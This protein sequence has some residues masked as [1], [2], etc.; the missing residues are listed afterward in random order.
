M[1]FIA[2][3]HIHSKYSRATSTDLDLGRLHAAAQ[4]KGIQVLGTGDFTHPAWWQ[5]INEQLVPAEEGLF[6]L[7]P[8]LAQQF[9][10]T[11]PER[12]RAPVR[13]MLVTEISNVYKKDGRTRKNHNLV[14]MPDF[15]AAERFTKKLD[16]IGNVRSDGRP[17]LGLPARDLLE[18]V[19]E[20]SPRAYLIPAHI[21]T[22]WFS[23]LGSK[24]GFDAVEECF[25]DLSHHIFALETGLSSDPPMNWRV[26]ALDRYT[27]I[28]NSD[29]HSPAKLGR[30]ANRFNCDLNFASIRAA[31]DKSAPETFLGTLEFFPEEGKYHLD[32]HRK[33]N[34]RSL[35]VQTRA[36][37]ELCP[38]CGKPLTLGVLFRVEALADRC[39]AVKPEGAAGFE[40]LVPLHHLLAEVLQIG[41]QSKRVALAYE[42]LLN[43]HGSELEILRSVPVEVLA[44]NGQPLLAEAIRRMREGN[45]QFEAGFDGQFGHLQIFDAQERRALCGQGSLF[46]ECKLEHSPVLQCGEAPVLQAA[47]APPLIVTDRNTWSLNLEQQAALD[48]G[49]GPLMIVAG[50]GTG[51]TRTITCRMAALIASEEVAAEN[52]LAVTFTNRAADEMRSRLKTTLGPEAALPLVATFH[53][54]CRQLLNDF[55]NRSRAAAIADEI[56]RRAVL[57]DA[58]L[59]LK[60]AGETIAPSPEALLK[61]IVQAKQR[62]LT[63]YDDLAPAADPG[64]AATLTK[65]YAAYQ[66]LLD[67]QGLCDFEDLILFCAR[68]MASS[69]ALRAGMRRRFS[70]VFVDE[71]QDINYGQYELLRQ[72][73]PAD[74]DLCVIGDPD[75]SIYGFRGADVHFF[76]RFESDYPTARIIRL[77]RNYRSTETIL[78]SAGQVIRAGR[79]A[80]TART[81]SHIDGYD[82]ITILESASAQAEATAIGRSIEALVGGTG[83]HALGFGSRG[84]LNQASA[85]SFSDFAVLYR[86]GEQGA[87]LA[88]TLEKAGLPCQ[89]TS[90]AEWQMQRAVTKLLS[91]LRLIAGQGSYADLTPLSDLISPGLGK[92]TLVLFKS[93]GYSQRLPLDNALQTALRLPLPEISL[94]RQQRLMRW[95]RRIGELNK[96]TAGMGV[97]EMVSHLAARQIAAQGAEA[98]ALARLAAAAQPFGIDVAA[99]LAAFA[100]QHDTD[101][102]HPQTEKV[103]LLTMHAAKGLEFP[104]VYIAGCEEGLIPFERPGEPPDTEEERRLFYVAVTRAGRRL[105][106]SWVRKR[107]RHGR[108]VECRPSRFLTD[109]EDHL[110]K[111]ESQLRVRP[112][113]AQ[114][115]LF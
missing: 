34:F 90:R 6:A 54:L 60:T 12:C 7:K 94:A 73:A 68:S 58:L 51:K 39:E 1:R 21:W 110:K 20:A 62:L 8:E 93:W 59:V 24:S 14:F 97:A 48:H 89:R 29:A 99:F 28:S 63:P 86:T 84:E 53:G 9:D 111:N 57:S 114:L 80:P 101:L 74:G 100:L 83:Y 76:S 33:C 96:E 78:C 71:F 81:Y 41:P 79:A 85:H 36:S 22:P 88:E 44:A 113:P 37:N 38:L 69:R 98:E 67:L 56:L 35:P 104:V 13:F 108:Q 75:Q 45:V 27:L 64:Q 16:K 10:L 77:T 72:L 92:E 115:E 18:I 91:L 23:L 2:D 50:P 4:I 40:H 106:L 19:L 26:S 43:R 66:N 46:A 61:M 25:D 95:I 42:N 87:L 11:V 15:I 109:I 70:H 30:E 105:F 102:Y 103:A 32:G 55:E 65:V 49:R 47:P 17:I 3:F 82:A 112:K 52:I 5:E 107:S 31:L